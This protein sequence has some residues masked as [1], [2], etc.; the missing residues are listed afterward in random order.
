MNAMSS[1]GGV[2]GQMGQSV[3]QYWHRHIADSVWIRLFVYLL[4]A[5]AILF[6]GKHVFKFEVLHV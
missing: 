3:S 2:A 5:L 6:Q 1:M 4:G